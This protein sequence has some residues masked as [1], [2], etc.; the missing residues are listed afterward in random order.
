MW[1]FKIKV[2]KLFIKVYE[3][4]RSELKWLDL[5]VLYKNNEKLNLIG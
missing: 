3:F 2:V 4:I 5:K 1:K